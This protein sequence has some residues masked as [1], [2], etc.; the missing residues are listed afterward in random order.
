MSKMQKRANLLHKW[1]VSS[2]VIINIIIII[3]I[4][5]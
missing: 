2:F 5:C 3:M 4:R 1:Y